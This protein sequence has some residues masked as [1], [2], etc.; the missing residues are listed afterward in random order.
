MGKSS[1]LRDL[2]CPDG[3]TALVAIPARPCRLSMV[4]QCVII[5]WLTRIIHGN[6][7]LLWAVIFSLQIGRV[8]QERLR[9]HIGKYRHPP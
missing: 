8:N 2:I 3:R 9:F 7:R 5:A 1:D 4:P 6:D